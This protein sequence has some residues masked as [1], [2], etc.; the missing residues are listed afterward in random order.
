MN[1]LVARKESLED[2]RYK[3]LGMQKP[4]APTPNA[5]GEKW[6]KSTGFDYGI[7]EIQTLSAP[8][9]NSFADRGELTRVKNMSRQMFPNRPTGIVPDYSKQ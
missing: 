5:A 9:K 8:T 2:K 4:T 3:F 6:L 1:S 7:D